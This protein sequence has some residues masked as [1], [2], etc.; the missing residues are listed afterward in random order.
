MRIRSILRAVLFVVTVAAIVNKECDL[1]GQ[2]NLTNV[3]TINRFKINGGP[4]NIKNTGCVRRCAVIRI[5]N[6]AF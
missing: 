3:I 6:I 4:M 1:L 2:E 5:R